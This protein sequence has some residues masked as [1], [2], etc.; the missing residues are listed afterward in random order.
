M[1]EELDYDLRASHY[2][3]AEA[4]RPC[5]KCVAMAQVYCFLLPQG[6][7]SKEDVDPDQ[8]GFGPDDSY[9][10][11]QF[12]AWAAS[13]A[14]KQWIAW[15]VPVT[16]QYLMS[17][18]PAVLSRLLERTRCY[19]PSLSKQ[20]ELTYWMNHCQQCGMR[21]GDHD[22]HN[23]PGG[24]FFPLNEM[25]ASLIQLYRIDEPFS[26]KG[27]YGIGTHMQA[28]FDSMKKAHLKGD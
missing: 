18:P 27:S 9:T 19:R 22:L 16:V 7:E 6:F 10:D 8:A 26:G 28:M 12:E 15:D 23:E 5:W 11:A 21:Q 25:D 24:S 3:I 2:Y 1:S 14:S 17:I 4:S 20:A 13:P